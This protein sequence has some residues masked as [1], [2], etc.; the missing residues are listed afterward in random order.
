MPAP[1]RPFEVGQCAAPVPVSPIRC[2]SPGFRWTQCASQTSSPSQPS[3]STYSSGRTPKRSMQN[4]SSSIVSA[5]WVWSRTPRCRA[6][7]AVSAI[8]SRL[9]LNGE[10]GASA[11]RTIA[12][13]AGS[14]KRSIAAALAARIAS[15]SSTRS[16]GGS[17]PSL[18]P[19]SIAPRHGWKRRPIARAASISTASRSPSPRGKM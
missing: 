1:S 15:R 6:S 8:S 3:S 5:R 18:A 16:S 4:V 13:G 9:T 2:A 12:P 14:W 17:P 11:I 7:S 19:R 10:V